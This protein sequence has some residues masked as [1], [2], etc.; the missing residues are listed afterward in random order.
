MVDIKAVVVN[1]SSLAGCW[2]DIWGEHY[3]IQGCVVKS[4]DGEGEFIRVRWRVGLVLCGVGA[5]KYS[6][7]LG[8]QAGFD[9]LLS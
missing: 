9:V 6:L 3:G 4:A 5:I 1:F 7:G 8:F 2:V